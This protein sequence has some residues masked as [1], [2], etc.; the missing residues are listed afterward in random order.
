[1]GPLKECRQ[2]NR[3]NTEE[4]HASEGGVDVGQQ[5]SWQMLVALCLVSVVEGIDIQLVPS[6][7]FTFQKGGIMKLTDV[8]ILTMVQVICLNMT[9]PQ[10]GASLQTGVASASEAHS[11]DWSPRRKNITAAH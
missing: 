10:R 1:M 2:F 4:S 9:A 11:D 5:P 8:A 3:H 6:C 7:E